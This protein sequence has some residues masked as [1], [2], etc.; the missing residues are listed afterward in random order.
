MTSHVASGAPVHT[1]LEYHELHRAR[2]VAWWRTLVGSGA[3]VISF[4]VLPLVVAIPFTIALAAQGDSQAQVTDFLGLKH[5]T[6][7]SLAYLNLALATLIP[8]AI[9]V[10]W[11]CHA[12]QPP[13]W[14]LSVAGRFR[15]RWFLTCLGLAAVTLVLTL[16]VGQ[17]LPRSP[18]DPDVSGH[19]HRFT[20]QTLGFLLVILLLTPLQAAGEEFA[21]RGYL[22]QAWGGLASRVGRRWGQVVAVLVP[23]ILFGLAHGIGQDVPVFFDRFAFGVVA[24]VLVIVTGGLEAGIAMHVLNNFA[25]FGLAL[26]YGSMT[27]ALTDTHGTWWLIPSTLTQ[28]LVYLALV[29][30]VARRRGVATRTTA[31][32]AAPMAAV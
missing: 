20:G 11:L 28:S 19:L 17:L 27:S 8:A 7:G 15:W 9:G 29:S 16:A 22:T 4:L 24:G 1:E 2:A 14:L 30:W 10:N 18:G 13:R 31:V 3:L 21:F 23:A 32:L 5:V 26:A 6:P 12:W 25:A